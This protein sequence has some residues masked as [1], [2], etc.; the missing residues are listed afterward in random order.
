MKTQAM[1]SMLLSFLISA[2][3]IAFAIAIYKDD[4]PTALGIV[5]VIGGHW[6]GVG[7]VSTGKTLGDMASSSVASAVVKAVQ[8]NTIPS[9]GT[10]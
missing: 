3:L 4:H 5:G 6:L 7:S 8:D 9:Q 2:G 1:V 10:S